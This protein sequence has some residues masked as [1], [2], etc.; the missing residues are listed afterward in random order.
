MNMQE[1]ESIDFRQLFFKFYRFW[2]FFAITIFIAL[3]IAFLFNKYTKP[4]Y[5]VSTTVL[6][7][8]D[9]FG[10]DAQALLGLGLRNPMQNLNNEIGILN[11]Y[12]LTHRAVKALNLDVSYY[13]EKNFITTEMYKESPFV[14]VFDTDRPQ[15]VDQK[16]HINIINENEYHLEAEGENIKMYSFI[17]DEILKHDDKDVTAKKISIN[18]DFRFGETVETEDYSFRI[19][20]SSNYDPELHNSRKMYFQFNM[21]DNMVKM[22]RGFDI[23]PINKDASIIEIKL[24]GNN[25]KKSVD[26]LNELTKQY[27]NRQLEKK[28]QIA[29]KTIEF[30]DSEIVGILDSLNSAETK[31]ENFR[32]ENK[33]ME[34][35][36]E[37]NQVFEYM[38]QLDQEKAQLIVKSKYYNYLKE[39]VTKNSEIDQLLVPSSMGIED[40]LLGNLIAELVK[41]ADERSAL[42]I[43]SR[44][45]NPAVAVVD[46]KN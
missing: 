21:L 12:T 23:E 6:I 25:V 38:N 14:V 10:G 41:L 27:L 42:L 3:V 29:T 40:P 32:T 17:E 8:E 11:S 15:P 39:Y 22:M 33:I 28:N 19:E 37:A 4:I 26:F 7:K 16:F 35:S 36:F 5:E 30:I 20:L 13:G 46:Q 34:L 31:L 2:Y 43:N 1:E 9:R 18:K 24:K 45:K 44:K